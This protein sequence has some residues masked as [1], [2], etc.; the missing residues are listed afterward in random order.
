M[1]TFSHTKPRAHLL[2]KVSLE[3]G[4]IRRR[5]SSQ[6]ISLFH[7]PV[8]LIGRSL[9]QNVTDFGCT[10][11]NTNCDFS[12]LSWSKWKM[13]DVKV[14]VIGLGAAGLVAL[15]NLKEE[16]FDVT[17]F[18]R[19]SYIGGLWK[20]SEDD[21]TSV[22]DTT[23]VNISKE[24]GCFSDF[25]YPD[26]VSSHP[27]GAQV[28]DYLL[29]Y[30]KH[31]DL[32]P[33]MKLDCPIEQ[34]VF[35]DDQQKWIIKIRDQPDICFDK[36]LIAIGGMVGLPNMPTIEN[37][38]KF[39]GESIHTKT[40]KRP[41]D[42]AGKRVMVVGFGNSAADTATQLVGI[43]DTIYLAHRNGA[44]V[45]PRIVDGRPADHTQTWR[46]FTA[47]NFVMRL[48]PIWGEKTFDKLLKSVQDKNFKVRPEWGFEPAQKVPLVS[49]TLVDY[50]ESG[51]I[52]STKGLRRV[53][54]GTA[55]ELDDGR[56]VEVDVIIWSTGYKANFSMIDPRFDPSAP[57]P[58]AWTK[59]RGLNGKS[60][61]RLW[62][63]VFSLEKPESLAFIGNVHFAAGGFMIFDMAAMAIA[64]V[65][66]GAS[67]LPPRA[68]LVHEVEKHHAWVVDQASRQ[69]NFSP[70][71]VEA[72]NWTR[73]MNDLGGTGVNEFLGYGWKGWWF[74]ARNM[75]FCHLLMDGIWTPHIFRVFDGKRKK[76]EGAKEAIETVNAVIAKR[77]KA[78]TS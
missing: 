41:S 30:A 26:S 58:D 37:M 33:Y 59:A 72:G 44:R 51:D 49:D 57:P 13:E 46:L 62:H 45:L 75:R 16:G 23:V 24:R 60:L 35:N 5:A 54:N 14:A 71:N 15:K 19:N 70:G 7:G 61:F 9:I 3:V 1:V 4:I 73:T 63:N 28:H 47:F 22:L 65:W 21:Q 31:F 11:V 67:A 12:A 52:E 39:E 55:V 32:M 66:K 2:S 48:F 76:W 69:S 36:I 25:P 6:A 17:G 10:T 64:Q 18:E 50:L 8:W 53:I 38:D 56:R 40:F 68:Q 27:T 42:F 74:W 77:K 78:K 34:I 20:Y 43:A 29:S